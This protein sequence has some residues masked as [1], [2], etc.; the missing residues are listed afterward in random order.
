M[1]SQVAAAALRPSFLVSSMLRLCAVQ[2][3][4]VYINRIP[5]QACPSQIEVSFDRKPYQGRPPPAPDPKQVFAVRPYS[6]PAERCKEGF[7]RA[8]HDLHPTDPQPAKALGLTESQKLSGLANLQTRRRLGFS[9]LD[10]RTLASPNKFKDE[11]SPSTQQSRSSSPIL[12]GFTLR[13]A[14]HDSLLKPS[15]SSSSSS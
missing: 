9:D 13:K 7:I 2:S 10:A 4:E 15:S 14:L 11:R 8:W 1:A 12:E 5:Y 3:G 6:S